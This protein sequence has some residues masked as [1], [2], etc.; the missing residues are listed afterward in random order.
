[1]PRR[2]RHRTSAPVGIARPFTP[3]EDK[4]LVAAARCGLAVE[5]YSAAIPGR[6]TGELLERRLQLREAGEL[7]LAPLL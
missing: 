4:E 1:M 5:F 6:T 3:D 7:E 2:R